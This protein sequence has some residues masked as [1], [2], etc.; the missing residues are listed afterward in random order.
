[1]LAAAV[2]W[3][4]ID[5]NVATDVSN[6]LHERAEFQPFESWEEVDALARELGP[7]GPLAIFCVGTGVRPEEALGLDWQHVD[8][9]ARVVVIHRAFAK[10]RLKTYNKTVRSRRRVPL[11]AK[12]VDALLELPRREGILFPAAE[13]GRIDINNWRSREWAPAFK[14]A[15]LE[16][17]AP[18]T[19]CATRSR[20]GVSTAGMGIFTLARRMGTSVRI[21]DATYGHLVRD[22]D[23]QDRDL[24]DAYDGPWARSG[25]DDDEPAA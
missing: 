24:L 21:I 5:R 14:A 18:S 9:A 16:H 2:K 25:H 23:D 22:A 1:M 11:R 8:L 12:V 7:F 4:W 20:P 19:T 15:A 6:P 17:R 13:G 3:Q 10:G